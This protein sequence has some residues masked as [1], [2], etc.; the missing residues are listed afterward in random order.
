MGD[1]WTEK[2][3]EGVVVDGDLYLPPNACA[4]CDKWF[5]PYKAGV[6]ND[7]ADLYCWVA[8]HREDA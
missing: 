3:T 8:D 6:P 1:P 2:R 7:T 4:V 5:P